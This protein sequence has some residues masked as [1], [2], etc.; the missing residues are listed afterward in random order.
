MHFNL[1][2]SDINASA[3]QSFSSLSYQLDLDASQLSNDDEL[4]FYQNII[5]ILFWSVELSRIDIDY[6]VSILSRYLAQPRTGHLVQALHILKYLDIYKEKT[7]AM[8]LALPNIATPV[9][10]VESRVQN[11]KSIYSDAME[12]ISY[13]VLIPGGRSIHMSFFVDAN[14]TSDKLTRRS[15]SGIIIY[16]NSAPILWYS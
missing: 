12:A 9:E 16:C 13:N 3:P 4:N 14:H 7:I 15:Q 10:D 6:E 11:M 1:K 2:L 5:G 8:N